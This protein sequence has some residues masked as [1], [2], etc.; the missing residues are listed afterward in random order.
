MTL[1]V[2]DTGPIRYLAVIQL[3]HVLPALF[4]M[5]VTPKAVFEELTH[6]HAPDAAREWSAELPPW[7]QVREA[8]PVAL[9]DVLDPGEAE[10]IALAESACSNGERGCVKRMRAI[11]VL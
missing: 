3:I 4:E 11:D 10:A 6:P 2:A 8:G 5:V 1:V 9:S 7:A